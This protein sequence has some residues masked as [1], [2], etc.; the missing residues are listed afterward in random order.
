MTLH[1]MRGHASS[2]CFPDPFPLVPAVMA[3]LLAALFVH[4]EYVMV[5][6]CTAPRTPEIRQAIA[7][8]VDEWLQIIEPHCFYT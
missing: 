2:T 6:V 4:Y 7:W 5:E 1:F 3:C 8:L